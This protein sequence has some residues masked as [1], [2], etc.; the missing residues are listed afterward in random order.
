MKLLR[1]LRALTQTLTLKTSRCQCST[2]STIQ[3]PPRPQKSR[4]RVNM[5]ATPAWQWSSTSSSQRQPLG[6]I[7]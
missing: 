6:L 5:W 3:P 4:P 1:S 2:F 7:K